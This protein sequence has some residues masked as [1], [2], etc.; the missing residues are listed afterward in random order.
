MVKNQLIQDSTVLLTQNKEHNNQCICNKQ[1]RHIIIKIK[2][3]YL[4]NHK[5]S[6][7]KVA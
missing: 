5:I 7:L 2:S 6:L 1:V 4:E 3:V